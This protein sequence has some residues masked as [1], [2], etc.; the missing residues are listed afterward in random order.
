[1][2]LW[3]KTSRITYTTRGKV[4]GHP[5]PVAITVLLEVEHRLVGVTESE[6]EG[7][8]GEVT[9]HVGSVTTPE[10]EQTLVTVGTREAVRDALV[11]LS[12]TALLDLQR[13][14]GQDTRTAIPA[15]LTDHL[16][17]VLDQELD[18]LDG[19]SGGLGNS[20]Q[21]TK[22]GQRRV[23]TSTRQETYR[24]HTTHHEIDCIWVPGQQS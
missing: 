8:G 24:R 14:H 6:V 15:E 21:M 9:E 17:L 12:E 20:L 10:R 3:N 16:I 18:T 22:L 5:P 4:T 7:L 13:G 19:G 23:E 1:M 11:R 2:F